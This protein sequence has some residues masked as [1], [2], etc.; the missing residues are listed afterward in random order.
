[1]AESSTPADIENK[2]SRRVGG[3]ALEHI[4]GWA[5]F[6]DLRVA[7]DPGVFIP[8]AKTEFLVQQ[9]ALHLIDGAIVVDLCCGSGAVGAALKASNQSI[10]LFGTDVDQRAIACAQRNADGVMLCGDLF[11]PLGEELQNRVNVIVANAPY[12]PTRELVYMPRDIREAEPVFTLDGGSDGLDIQRKI[13]QQAA[14]W[15]APGGVVLMEIGITQIG[16]AISMMVDCGVGVETKVSHDSD[17][18]VVIGV[19][20]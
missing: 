18:A 11:D 8:R 1:M 9:A 3:E 7:V 13:T 2:V 14:T 5:E 17:V 10:K 12:V 4:L 19:V 20:G 6:C 15:L 16:G